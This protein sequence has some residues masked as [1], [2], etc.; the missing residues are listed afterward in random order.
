MTVDSTDERGL[1]ESPVTL[2]STDAKI[3]S[4]PSG[5]RVNVGEVQYFEDVAGGAQAIYEEFILKART[6]QNAH[7][8]LVNY[9]WDNRD[10]LPTDQQFDLQYMCMNYSLEAGMPRQRCMQFLDLSFAESTLSKET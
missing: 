7:E 8:A 10:T 4:F 2:D 3:F 1:G 5:Q 9:Y 6:A